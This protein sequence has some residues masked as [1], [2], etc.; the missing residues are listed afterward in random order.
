[1]YRKFITN[2]GGIFM[3]CITIGVASL[4]LVGVLAGCYQTSEAQTEHTVTTE[5]NVQL[6]SSLD[7]STLQ[8]QHETISF[9]KGISTD[10]SYMGF[11]GQHFYFNTDDGIYVFDVE[12]ETYDKVADGSFYEISQNGQRTLTS[13]NDVSYVLDFETM[14]KTKID[15][16]NIQDLIFFANDEGSKV[17]HIND[18]NH[19]EIIFNYIDV[20]TGA[21]QSWSAKGYNVSLTAQ[22][23]EDGIY[24]FG[25]NEQSGYGIYQ[26]K[27]NQEVVKITDLDNGLWVE[28]SDFLSETKF[29]FSG[30]VDNQTGIY[31]KDIRT[32]KTT[33]L[34][35]GGKSKEG[36]WTPSFSLSPDQSKILFD[37]PVQVGEEFKGDVYVAELSIAD[38]QLKNTTRLIEKGDLYAVIALSGKWSNDSKTAYIH[39]YNK[40]DF[41]YKT[42][43][44][45]IFEE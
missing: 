42:V 2:E 36:I 11:L 14:Q 27:D 6:I 12:S 38:E 28:S 7:D 24:I 45:F 26:I 39:T 21:K 35:A 33:L 22:K 31:M 18:E 41:T 25:E 9:P 10:T 43:E 17:F 4:A 15:G 30:S 3:K 8:V 34:V 37:T 13:I 19:E 20:K 44:K 1:M 40:E 16:T 32:D 29:I 5:E 23:A